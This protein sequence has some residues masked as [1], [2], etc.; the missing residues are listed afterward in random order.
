M[1]F[2]DFQTSLC[3]NAHRSQLFQSLTNYINKWQFLCDLNYDPGFFMS[4]ELLTN[5][6]NYKQRVINR[7]SY[8][9]S[10]H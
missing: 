9:Y 5:L 8:N 3:L 1:Y 2:I 6:L 4:L 10:N 7:I